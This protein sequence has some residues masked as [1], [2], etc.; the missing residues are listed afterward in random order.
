MSSFSVDMGVLEVCELRDIE[1][2]DGDRAP[3]GRSCGLMGTGGARFLPLP[4]TLPPPRL[5]L[6]AMLLTPPRWS[7]CRAN[8]NVQFDASTRTATVRTLPF[9]VGGGV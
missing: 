6:A 5:L 8:A 9:G 2:L 7:T 4:S 3:E 1:L